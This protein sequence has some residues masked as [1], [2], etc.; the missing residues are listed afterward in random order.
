MLGGSI[1]RGAP[2][3]RGAG[4]RPDRR[5][6]G[7]GRGRPRPAR[8]PD[9]Q[10]RRARSRSRSGRSR[11]A[12]WRARAWCPRGRPVLGF[13]PGFLSVGAATASALRLSSDG[14]EPVDRKRVAVDAE[15][16]DH[17]LGDR[18]DVGMLAEVLARMDVG[19]V[20]LD[21]RQLHGQ[22]ASR[23]ATEVWRVGGR[24]DDDAGGL[25]GAGLLDPVDQLA[26]VVGLA[27]F[28]RKAVRACRRRGTASR[29][30]RAWRGRRSPARA[31]RAGSGWGR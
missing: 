20:D 18:R 7:A 17:G 1:G 23:I 2:T 28:D 9:A 10:R 24:V 22:S 4:A 16:A 3:A 26:L 12:A 14:G 31:C 29:R 13:M 15:A 19:D 6:G 11:R 21:H 8:D 30:P 27:E 25:L 5:A